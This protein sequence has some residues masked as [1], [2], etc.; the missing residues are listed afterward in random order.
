MAWATNRYNRFWF[1]GTKDATWIWT[2]ATDRSSKFEWSE[3]TDQ[4]IQEPRKTGGSKPYSRNAWRKLQLPITRA[5]GTVTDIDAPDEPQHNWGIG[6][7]TFYDG[8]Q[9]ILLWWW[10]QE[11][12]F[13][14]LQSFTPAATSQTEKKTEPQKVLPKK[15]GNVAAHLQGLWTVALWTEWHP[16]LVVNKLNPQDWK[17]HTY[18][19]CNLYTNDT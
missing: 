19:F 9:Y 6:D 16:R 11:S 7:T 14:F 5:I 4:Q 12:L 18:I 2:A 1:D 10:T 15:K 13:S 3:P 8:W 17:L